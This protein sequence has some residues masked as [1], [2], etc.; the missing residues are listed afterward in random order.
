MSTF[1]T[2]DSINLKAQCAWSVCVCGG[3]SLTG[4]AISIIFVSTNTCL[5]GEIVSLFSYTRTFVATNIIL[6]RQK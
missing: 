5:S 2:H 1:I 4:T 6:L 3:L